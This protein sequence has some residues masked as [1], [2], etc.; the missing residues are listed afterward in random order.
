MMN[1][2]VGLRTV[3]SLGMSWCR[4]AGL[5]TRSDRVRKVT[6]DEHHDQRDPDHRHRHPR[7]R[8]ARPVDVTRLVQV[9]RSRATRRVGRRQAGGG[10]VH[11]RARGSVRSARRRWPAGTNTRRSTHVDSTTP[12][13]SRGMPHGAPALMDTYGVKAQIL[14]PN[15][16][17][18]D[19]KSI[20][21]MGDTAL[22]LACIEAYNDF[23]V[24][25]G[26]E[27][28]RPIHRRVRP[29]V[30]GPRRPRWPRSSAARRTVT[31]G[32]C[33]RRTRRT[34]ACPS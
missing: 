32:S 21:G 17:V 18:F 26:N 19:A 20:V 33:S 9:G 15:V 11:R 16:A 25:F 24:D 6:P 27:A 29:A 4:L 31:R 34:S 14:Y 3:V 8:A 28:A 10:L 1:S 5:H 2:C 30:L 22:Q 12:T 13:R 23:L 7:G